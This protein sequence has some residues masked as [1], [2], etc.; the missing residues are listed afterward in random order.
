LCVGCHIYR[1]LKRLCDY[2]FPIVI[3][4]NKVDIENKTD[5]SRVRKVKRKEIKFHRKKNL[6]YFEMSMKAN[7]H[8]YEPILYLLKKLCGEHIEF[9]PGPAYAPPLMPL[10]IN[11]YSSEIALIDMNHAIECGLP[12]DCEYINPIERRKVIS[13]IMY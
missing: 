2:D 10:C 3:C 11:T 7:Y 8:V 4:G 5:D 13:R 12:E 9:V 6:Q 1:D